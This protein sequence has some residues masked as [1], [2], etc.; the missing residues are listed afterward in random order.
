MFVLPWS[1]AWIIGTYPWS[2][3]TQWLAHYQTVLRLAHWIS[4]LR[5]SAARNPWLP[6]L[7][8]TPSRPGPGIG[9]QAA[10]AP[11]GISAIG[12]GLPG[13][14]S[15]GAEVGRP[16]SSVASP[17][18]G[19]GSPVSAREA[20]QALA[21]RPVPALGQGSPSAPGSAPGSA[22]PACPSPIGVGVPGEAIA[23]FPVEF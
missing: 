10:W 13:G 6:L 18:I 16:E 9:P 12:P 22:V 19:M 14:N 11:E 21:L 3:G 20:L 23:V 7:T 5:G 15:L 2:L 4:A 8:G 17:F 1:A